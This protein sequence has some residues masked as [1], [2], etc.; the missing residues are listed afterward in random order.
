MKKIFFIKKKKQKFC[1]SSQFLDGEELQNFCFFM[2]FIGI[3]YRTDK[4]FVPEH[5][6]IKTFARTKVLSYRTHFFQNF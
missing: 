4:S 6:K 1:N 3:S 2:N 5:T